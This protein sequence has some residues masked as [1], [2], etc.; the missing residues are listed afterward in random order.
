MIRLFLDTSARAL[1]IAIL[2]DNEIMKEFYEELDRDLSSLTLLKIK[3]MMEDIKILPNDIDQ[4]ICVD[5]PG[6]FTGL[7]IGVTIAKTYAWGL[8][9]DLIKVSSLFTM[10]TS[11]TTSNYIIPLIDARRG[12]VYAGIYNDN[13][14]VILKDQ[15]IK[16]E[17][18]TKEVEN[19]KGSYKYVSND[20]FKEIDITKY[21]P[22]I[23]N[24][25]KYIKEE[26]INPH[27]FVPNYL[28]STEA[29]E[30][31]NK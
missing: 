30:N 28:K 12:Y 25:F 26:K 5:G 20:E 11:I 18:L 17:D 2:K 6:S 7:R 24:L 27:Y 15:Y 13:Y 3:E 8:S 14:E 16:L 1:S 29:E 4:I 23:K 9:K 10:A 22:D 19:L 21:K 31:L